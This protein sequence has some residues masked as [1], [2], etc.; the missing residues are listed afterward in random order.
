MAGSCSCVDAWSAFARRGTLEAFPDDDRAA[1]FF[2]P[3]SP[4]LYTP[5]FWDPYTPHCDDCP[6]N[7]LTSD[8]DST[9]QSF[10]ERLCYIDA[11]DVARRHKMSGGHRASRMEAV[12]AYL[13]KA[14]AALVGDCDVHCRMGQWVDGHRHVTARARVLLPRD[15][16]RGA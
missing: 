11:R 3:C 4:L 8:D 5:A 7:V 6:V 9:S 12:S 16:L 13:C 15:Q 2:R 14:S 1:V 10:V